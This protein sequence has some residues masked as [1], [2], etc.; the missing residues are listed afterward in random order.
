MR[1]LIIGFVIG[2]LVTSATAQF[3]QIPPGETTVG[4]V[5]RDT[6]LMAGGKDADGNPHQIQVD[7]FGYVICSQIPP[8]SHWLHGGDQNRHEH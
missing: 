2:L 5:H 1:N 6:Y 8:P 4:P 3:G 7:R